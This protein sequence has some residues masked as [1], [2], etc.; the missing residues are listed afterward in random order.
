MEDFAN[1]EVITED[2]LRQEL[3][4]QCRQGLAFPLFAGSAA[5]GLGVRELLSGLARYLPVQASQALSALPLSGLVFKVVVQAG[6]E[7]LVFVRLFAGQLQA[8][9]DVTVIAQDGLSE[10]IKIKQ[11]YGLKDG[12]R[13]P[14]QHVDAGDIAI[15][16][17]EQV[18]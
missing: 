8:R 2:R 7:R 17:S 14:V 9:A 11:L 18:K 15:F 1:N 6:G 5:R 3:G 4:R 10:R 13:K 16:G 12:E